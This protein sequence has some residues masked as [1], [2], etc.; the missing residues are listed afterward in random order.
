MPDALDRRNAAAPGSV[1]VKAQMED[2][3][4]HHT[5]HEIP[6][7]NETMPELLTQAVTDRTPPPLRV[8]E[9]GCG[10]GNYVVGLAK[11]GFDV[12]GVDIA[13]A[14]IA[15]ATKAAAEAGVTCRFVAADVLRDLPTV[16]GPYD[17]AYD[18]ELLHHVFPEDR[19]R[20]ICNVRRLLRPGGT[21]LSVCFSEDD[22]QFGGAGKYRQTPLGTLLYFSSEAEI[23]SLL[24]DGFIIEEL[25]TIDVRGKHAAHRAVCA[26]ASKRRGQAR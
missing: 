11:L 9:F 18:W 10:A 12:T 4:R 16:T 26:L 19:G 24:T 13:E 14:A 7:N 22:P 20:Y 17:F 25:R 2:I 8:I 15:I 1:N 23:E 3:Y 5:L 21:Y 6:W